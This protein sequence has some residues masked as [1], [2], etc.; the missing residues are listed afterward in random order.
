MNFAK[1]SISFVLATVMAASS[2]FVGT[3]A[4]AAAPQFTPYTAGV[5]QAFTANLV[6][7]KDKD[8]KPTGYSNEYTYYSFT[9][10]TTGTYEIVVNAAPL[11]YKWDSTS[12]KLIP[13]TAKEDGCS[14]KYDARIGIYEDESSAYNEENSVASISAVSYNSY[15]VKKYSDGEEYLSYVPY[16]TTLP[17]YAT[18]SL[19]ANKTYYIAAYSGEYFSNDKKDANGNS[20]LLPGSDNVYEEEFTYGTTSFK[21]APTNWSVDLESKYKDVTYTV[22]NVPQVE[23]IF[24]FLKASVY[25]TGDA[26][27]VVVPDTISAN[28]AIVKSVTGTSNKNITS[29]TLGKNTETVSGFSNLRSLAAVNLNSAK[30]IS[31]SAFA[32]DTALTSVVIPGTVKSIG[33]EA[34]SGCTSLSNVAISEGV[35]IIDNEAFFETAL[36]G[37]VIPASVASIGS[38]AFGF[39]SNFDTNTVTPYDVI[40]VVKEGFVIGGTTN[41]AAKYAAQ[42]GIAFYNMSAGCPH[43]YNTTTVEATLFAKGSKTGVCPLCGA[44]TKKTLAKKTFKIKSLK[45]KKAALVVKAP[46]QAGIKGYSVEVSTSKKF[47]KKTTK[48]TTVKTTK[49]LKKTI[50]GLKSGKKYYVRV[51]AFTKVGKKTVYSKYTAVKSVKVK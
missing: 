3:T 7:E 24:D 30:T 46:A 44:T 8:G 50:K 2:L 13:L 42:S 26:N 15:E 20:I 48:K 16:T 41:V 37:V 29:L 9:P 25:Y 23:Q 31:G 36:S 5:N 12:G 43:P 17:G 33:S 19:T 14:T 34:F 18:V 1:K 27:D 38:Y 28:G 22:N 35:K 39:E 32:N 51:R 11:Y 45:A 49:A 40:P 4:F 21:I 6:V 47:T 10:Q